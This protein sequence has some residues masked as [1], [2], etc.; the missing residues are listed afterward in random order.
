ME[1]ILKFTEE[2]NNFTHGVEFGA[3][4]HKLTNGYDKVEN[5]GFPVRIENKELI[6]KACVLYNYTPVFGKI[7]F[8]EWIQFFA[9]KNTSLTN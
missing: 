9:I 3:I 6:K 2:N 5:N 4:F 7:Y 8:D 1:L